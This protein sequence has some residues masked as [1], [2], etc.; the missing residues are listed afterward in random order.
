MRLK[1]PLRVL[2]SVDLPPATS[3]YYRLI[4]TLSRCALTQYNP[5]G[6][7]AQRLSM[8]GFSMHYFSKAGPKMDSLFPCKT[9]IQSIPGC[10]TC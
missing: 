7:K 10:L 1:V 4:Q 8:Q 9:Q 2:L 6:P 3:D 5:R